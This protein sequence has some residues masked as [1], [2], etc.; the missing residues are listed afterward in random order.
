MPTGHTPP[1]ATLWPKGAPHLRPHRGG[2]PSPTGHL[3]PPPPP[4]ATYAH[5]LPHWPEKRTAPIGK[6]GATPSPASHWPPTGHLLAIREAPPTGPL[7]ATK[8]RDGAPSPG[9]YTPDWAPKTDLAKWRRRPPTPPRLHFPAFGRGGAKS[10]PPLPPPT[11]PPLAIPGPPPLPRLSG[12]VATGRGGGLFACKVCRYE[13]ARVPY[14]PF[15]APYPHR[16]TRLAPYGHRPPPSPLAPTHPHRLTGRPG[17]ST[18]RPPFDA[19]LTTPT[20]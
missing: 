20:D 11:G 15:G 17:P 18:S 9:P 5:R 12:A 8:G 4:L 19:S 7:L 16:L 10:R 6:R 14:T 2:G 3:W 13:G 1:G